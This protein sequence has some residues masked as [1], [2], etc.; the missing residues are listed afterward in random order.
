M[1]TGLRFDGEVAIVTGAGGGLG[2]QYA[3]DLASRGAVVVVNDVAA[4]GDASAASTVAEI[5]GAGGHAVSRAGDVADPATADD[6]VATALAEG[7]RL[8]VVINNAGAPPTGPFPETPATDFDRIVDISLGA[9]IRLARAA[10]PRL[11]ERGGRIVNVTSHSVFGIASSSPYIV[12]KAGTW[13][14]TK[15]LAYDGRDAG[16]KVNAVMPMAYTRMTAQIEDEDL[17][18]FVKKHLPISKVS[19][20]VIALA[21]RDVAQSGE[22]FHAGGGLVAPVGWGFGAG[23]VDHEPTAEHLLATMPGLAPG[24]DITAF[25]DVNDSVAHIFSLIS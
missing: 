5:T 16:I 6:L 22:I 13:G 17:L 12:A 25:T 14:L 23:I 19:P 20:L 11:A 18:A 21:H 7:G 8:D 3:V 4:R 10:W 2:K 24:A 1:S 15:A 9:S